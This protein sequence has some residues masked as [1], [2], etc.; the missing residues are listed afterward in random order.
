M[1]TDQQDLQ[2]TYFLSGVDHDASGN[3]VM[4][5]VAELE[6]EDGTAEQT[7]LTQVVPPQLLNE[8]TK[9]VG[10][11]LKPEQF[12][13]LFDI[14]D[15]A[16]KEFGSTENLLRE[17]FAWLNSPQTQNTLAVGS[18]LESEYHRNLALVQAAF[19]NGELGQGTNETDDCNCSP[20]P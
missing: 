10:Q 2:P 15:N 17:T 5:I 14:A 1:T 18:F 9:R 7:F 8:I 3:L 6:N 19:A 16:V 13:K 4:Q 12:H 11:A 20:R